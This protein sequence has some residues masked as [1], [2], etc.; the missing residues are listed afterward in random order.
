M[1]RVIDNFLHHEVFDLLRDEALVAEY[2]DWLGP[3]GQMYKRICIIDNPFVKE[4]LEKD[5]NTDIDMLGMAFRLNYKGEEPNQAIH[6]DVGWGTHA[7]VLY[8]NDDP[9]YGGT[10]FWRHIESGKERLSPHDLMTYVKVRKDWEDSSK[11]QMVDAVQMKANRAV[12]Y[13]SE[14]FHSRYPFEAFGSTPEDG[15]LILVAFFTP[16]GVV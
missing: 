4:Q 9:N 3:D 6:T 5:L 10:A 13:E 8:L 2:T 16:K 15:R 11:W 1:V 12:I 14:L 7:M